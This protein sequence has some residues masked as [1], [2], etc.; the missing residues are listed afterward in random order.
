MNPRQLLDINPV[1]IDRVRLVIMAALSGAKEA[2]DFTTLLETLE[3]TKGNLSAHLRKLEEAGMIEVTK[4]FV[5]RKP[6]TTYSCTKEGRKEMARYLSSV[7]AMLA[8]TGKK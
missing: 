6:R 4:E 1:L 5:E 3:L 2:V 8:V 7:E